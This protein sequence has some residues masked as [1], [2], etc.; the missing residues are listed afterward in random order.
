[1]SRA[2]GTVHS[3][4][5]R[6]RVETATRTI[7]LLALLADKGAPVRLKDLTAE[8]GWNKTTVFRLVRTLQEVGA[9]RQESPHGFVLGP[10][11]ITIGQA[12]IHSLEL[13][14]VARPHLE[15]LHNDTGET[16]NLAVLDRDGILIVDRVE[17]RQILGLHLRP[18]STLP[19]YCT[20]V[21]FVLLAWRPAE[22]VQALLHDTRFDPRGPKTVSSMEALLERLQQV[23]VQGYAINDEEL[24]A[25]HRAAAAPIRDHT[26]NVVAAINLSVTAARR[27]RRELVR[28]LIPALR[29][30]AYH[31]SSELGEEPSLRG[32]GRGAGES[33]ALA[34]PASGAPATAK[35]A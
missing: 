30:T 31:I 12:A 17:S 28:Q 10:I 3:S 13:A 1:M 32:E 11:M 16:V 27:T 8:L 25:G 6:Y 15:R 21:G 4:V 24:A 19:A 14:S 18:G 9:V 2:R 23:R 5:N 7:E 26:G 34:D 29:A 22:E 33:S 35:G 20:S